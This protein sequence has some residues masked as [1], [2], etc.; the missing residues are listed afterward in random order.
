MERGNKWQCKSL[1]TCQ[2]RKSL[3]RIRYA[4]LTIKRRSEPHIVGL[5][6]IKCH[7]DILVTRDPETNEIDKNGN[8]IIALK[9][10]T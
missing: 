4:Y 9:I 2:V 5:L 1:F 7:S 3:Y 6:I 10:I 8:I